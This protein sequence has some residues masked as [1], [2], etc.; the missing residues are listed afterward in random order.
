MKSKFRIS[1]FV[2]ALLLSLTACA[3]AA[4]TSY[5]S[6]EALQLQA[7]LAEEAPP[8]E[9]P[10]ESVAAG[11]GSEGIIYRTGSDQSVNIGR[12]SDRLV[13]KDAEIK[14]LVEDSDV[15]I[16]RVTQ[17]VSDVGGYIISSRVW[18]EDW[19]DESYKYSS[20]TIG[21]PATQFE[22]SLRRLR[23]LA[24]RVIDEKAAGEDVTDQFVDLQSR[25]ESLQ[26]TRERILEFL[27]RAKTVEEAL[28]VNEELSKVESQIEELQGRIN[29]LSDRAAFSTITIT[30]EP[31]LPEIVPTPTSTPQ[32]T[33]TPVPWDPSKTFDKAKETLTFT[34]RGILDALIWIGVVILPV[35]GLP[36]VIVWIA[37]KYFKNKSSDKE[38]DDKNGA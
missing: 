13:I 37:M 20:I 36:L 29:Y 14:L 2:L 9:S 19:G 31:D 38:P 8:P 24:L 3:P 18:Y 1:I 26:A 22:R 4:A 17:V 25:L 7:P 21:V 15:A 10:A 30:I 35:V 5:V 23:D 11:S 32:P 27:D 28:S 33:R 34:Y 12:S 6:D 16:D